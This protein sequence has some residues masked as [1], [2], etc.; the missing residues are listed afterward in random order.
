MSILTGI[1]LGP[2]GY[3]PQ[4]SSW[5]SS[6]LAF[7]L[8]LIIIIMSILTGIRLGPKHYHHQHSFWSSSSSASSPAFILVL[9]IISICLGPQHYHHQHPHRHSSWSSSS[10]PAFIL[11]LSLMKIIIDENS[12]ITKT[13]LKG[14]KPSLSY[15][16][17]KKADNKVEA[18]KIREDYFNKNSGTK[19]LNDL[20]NG[21]L[22]FRNK[23]KVG[24]S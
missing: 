13:V 3:H 12:F 5:S 14:G 10:S 7:I 8:V 22:I 1:R 20:L 4:H 9:I 24:L 23:S 17:D 16:G 2:Q 6:L 18:D 21:I 11:V 19:V 15:K